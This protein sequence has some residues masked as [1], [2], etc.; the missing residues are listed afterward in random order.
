MGGDRERSEKLTISKTLVF[1]SL[2]GPPKKVQIDI[3]TTLT[4][5]RPTYDIFLAKNPGKKSKKN[6]LDFKVWKK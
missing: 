4:L 3:D 6:V 1:V 5:I 2:D